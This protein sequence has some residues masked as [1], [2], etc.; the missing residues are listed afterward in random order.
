MIGGADTPVGGV[1][2][3]LQPL[4]DKSVDPTQYVQRMP[5][6]IRLIAVTC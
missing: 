2:I 5:V 4:V 6:I 3:E 1:V